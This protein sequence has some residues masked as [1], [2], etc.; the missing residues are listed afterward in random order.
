LFHWRL[1]LLTA[2]LLGLLA[3]VWISDHPAP[4]YPYGRFGP[5]VLAAGI[6]VAVVAGAVGVWRR[7]WGMSACPRATDHRAERAVAADRGPPGGLPG[8]E[9]VPGRGR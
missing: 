4:A 2:V 7:L 1:S 8:S 3:W 6:L 5:L 9:S